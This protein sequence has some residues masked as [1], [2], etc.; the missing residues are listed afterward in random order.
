MLS[1]R[2]IHL[3]EAHQEQ[4]VTNVIQEMHRHPDIVQMRRLADAELRERGQEILEN[5]GQWLTAGH[6]SQIQHRYEELGAMRFTESIPLHECVRSLSIIRQKMV[7]FVHEQDLTGTP[8]ELY[9]EEELERRLSRF[10]DAL[11]INMVRGYENAWNRSE[12]VS[13]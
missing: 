9:A 6:H 7:D 5:L 4:I 3:I 13:V 8:V 1:G 10:F 11:I 2:L 12:R